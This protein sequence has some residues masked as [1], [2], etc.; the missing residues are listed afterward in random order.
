ML[1]AQNEELSPSK[2]DD[3]MVTRPEQEEKELGP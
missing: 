1:L 3:K 2:D